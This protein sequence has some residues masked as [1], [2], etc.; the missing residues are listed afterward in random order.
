MDSI[1]HDLA[2]CTLPDGRN[3][4]VLLA[5]LPKDTNPGDHLEVSSDGEGLVQ[6]SIDIA[7]T[8]AMLERN[9]QALEQLNDSDAG[10]TAMIRHRPTT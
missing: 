1:E 4:D 6:F 8:Q 3:I 9:R 5:W 10:G 2:I 7:A